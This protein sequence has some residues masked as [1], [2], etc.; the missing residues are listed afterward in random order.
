MTGSTC[1][2][3]TPLINLPSWKCRW[4]WHHFCCFIQWISKSKVMW[5]ACAAS[6]PKQ[7]HEAPPT[8]N[9]SLVFWV[10]FGFVFFFLRYWVQWWN[11]FESAIHTDSGLTICLVLY[12]ACMEKVCYSLAS[13]PGRRR[14]GL[15]TSASSNCIRMLRHGNCNISLQQTSACDA[16]SRSHSNEDRHAKRLH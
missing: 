1:T 2:W 15:G 3:P 7:N 13:F 10:F 16:Y 5:S 4:R 14:N 8:R 9:K 12:V 6:G 11:T